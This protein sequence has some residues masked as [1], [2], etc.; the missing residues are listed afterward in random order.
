MN[1]SRFAARNPGL[2]KMYGTTRNEAFHEQLEA[3]WRN[4][5]QQTGRNVHVVA[6][7]ATLAKLL[8]GQLQ[9]KNYTIGHREHELLRTASAI[10]MTEPLRFEPLFNH[11]TVAAPTVAKHTRITDKRPAGAIAAPTA[12]PTPKRLCVEL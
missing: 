8:A 4:V 12:S 10:L 11:V 3:F 6:G 7:V 5:V 1:G 9:A 2:Q